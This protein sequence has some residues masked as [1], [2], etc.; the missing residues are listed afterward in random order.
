[1]LGRRA[2]DKL[3]YLVFG[4]DSLAKTI[5]VEEELTNADL[6]LEHLRFNEMLDIC[7]HS[8]LVLGYVEATTLH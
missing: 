5:E 8:D 3:C 6:L 7:I 2:I 1:M 4:D